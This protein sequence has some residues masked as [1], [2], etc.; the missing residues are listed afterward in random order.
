MVKITFLGGTRE[1][2]RSGI[3]IESKNGNGCVLDYGIR[4]RG[5]ERLPQDLDTK[6]LK[7]QSSSWCFGS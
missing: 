3:L 5:E 2:G 4:F 7:Y 1:V 6:N